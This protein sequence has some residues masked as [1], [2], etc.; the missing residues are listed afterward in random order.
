MISV[1]WSDFALKNSAPLSGNSYAAMLNGNVIGLVEKYWDNR[2]PGMG[3]GDRLDRKVVVPIGAEDV[4]YFRCPSYVEPQMGLP[5]KA[6]LVQRQEG[7]APYVQTYVSPE[8]VG[9]Y[10]QFPV[11]SPVA[12]SASIVCYSVEALLE[13]GGKRSTD[14]DWEIVC[15]L[16]STD[17]QEPMTPLTMARNF[18]QKEGGT[19]G[20]YSAKDFAEAIWY[21]STRKGIP[22]RGDNL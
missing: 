11:I 15:I 8:D 10:T 1:G 6:R 13:N 22:V 4:T 12:T 2:K 21:W 5:V 20:E 3:E 16:A 19:F 17:A 9:M 18:L 14:C 7:E